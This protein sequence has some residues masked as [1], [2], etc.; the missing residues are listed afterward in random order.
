ML[1]VG[2]TFKKNGYDLCVLDLINYDGRN[3]ALLAVEKDKLE[4]LF[5]EMIKNDNN[6]D[7]KLVSDNETNFALFDI[8]ESSR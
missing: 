5:Y 7:L 1:E 6:F 4:Y 8:I 3:F 2:Q